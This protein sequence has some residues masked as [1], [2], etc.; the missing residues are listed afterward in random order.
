MSCYQACFA[1]VYREL[2]GCRLAN[3]HAAE[4]KKLGVRGTLANGVAKVESVKAAHPPPVWFVFSGAQ[5]SCQIATLP[6]SLLHSRNTA[7]ALVCSMLT[8]QRLS[9]R[10]FAQV[11]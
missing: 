11:S 10:D 6:S 4:I 3:A 9:C 7:C 1:D 2:L 8:A 5:F